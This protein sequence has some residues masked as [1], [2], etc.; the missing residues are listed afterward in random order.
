[1][2]KNIFFKKKLH[3]FYRHVHLESK[4]N[5]RR[6]KWFS[7]K[8][9]FMNLIST[10]SHKN[11]PILVDLTVMFDGNDESYNKD[12]LSEFMASSK[13]RFPHLKISVVK[14]AG[15]S[16]FASFYYTL[17][18]IINHQYG[19]SDWL[20]LLENDYLHV[21]NW[22]DKFSA[23]INSNND[24]DYVSLYDHSDKYFADMYNSLSS[25]IYFLGEHHWRSTPS[26]CASFL[27]KSKTLTEDIN[28]IKSSGGDH[29]FFTALHRDRNRTLITP[30][31]GLATHCMAKHLSPGINWELI[32]KSAI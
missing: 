15:G 19:S 8:S 20:Y 28:L 4:N 23:L 6:P 5:T 12:F 26:A 3:I 16:D 11:L 29:H 14:F 25:K 9:C 18:Y 2:I 30:I 17:D 32:N 1:M 31:P 21:D 10:I 27:F 24:F 7:H 22:V 13:T